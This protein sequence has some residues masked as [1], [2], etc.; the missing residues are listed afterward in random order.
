MALKVS[1][2]AILQSLPFISMMLH[3]RGYDPTPI[4][5]D[6]DTTFPVRFALVARPPSVPLRQ[7]THKRIIPPIDPTSRM[8]VLFTDDMKIGVDPIRG[9]RDWMQ[10]HEYSMGIIFS[11]EGATSFAGK[12]ITTYDAS[13]EM[14]WY[15][16]F[17]FCVVDHMLIP[18]HTILTPK[19][20]ENFLR[21]ANLKK[22]TSLH[23]L[24]I[25]DPVSRYY[26]LKLGDV[27]RFERKVGCM[28][29]FVTYRVV[30]PENSD[31]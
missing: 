26:G 18:D 6:K 14:L 27:V 23:R 19:Q 24:K 22:D 9:L 11:G 12:E 20:K 29:P 2:N 21:N 17:G 1:K 8:V 4:S 5:V 15:S 25:T 3:D 16:E 7:S 28:E 13:I 30:V 31:D 10:K